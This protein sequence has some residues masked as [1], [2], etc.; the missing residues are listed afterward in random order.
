MAATDG[1]VLLLLLLLLVVQNI[2]YLGLVPHDASYH[3]RLSVFWRT[4]LAVT[5]VNPAKYNGL[6]L[7]SKMIINEEDSKGL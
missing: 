1:P 6:G 4:P 7:K 5:K 3:T 2:E